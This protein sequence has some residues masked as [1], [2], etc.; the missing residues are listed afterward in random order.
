MPSTSID[1]QSAPTIPAFAILALSLAAFGSGISLRVT[2]ALLPKLS[3]DF[4][5]SLGE[6]SLVITVF[7]IAYG[8]AQLMFGPLGD[9]FGKYFVIA[10]G[11]GACAVTSLFCALAGSFPMLLV[12]R[13]VAGATA[14]AIIPLS[15]AWIGDVIP[16]QHRQPVLAKFLIGQILG[17]SAGV[18][19][20]GVAAE[21]FS[22]RMPFFGIA[23]LFVPIC[24]LLFALN[25]RLPATV[26]PVV[27]S[28]AHVISRMANEFALVLAKPW[29]RVVLITVF[30]E[31][32]FLYG[33]FAFFVAHLHQAFGL[34]LSTAGSLVMLYGFGGLA[35]AL[36][37]SM[38]VKRLGEIGLS[39]WGGICVTLSYITM[40]YAPVW[41]CAVPACFMAGLGF[42]MLHNTLQI[43]ATQMAVER[44]GVAVSAFAS[45]FFLG[46]ATGVGIAGM[47]VEKI[48]IPLVITLGGLGVLCVSQNFSRLRAARIDSVVP[49]PLGT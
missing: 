2:D 25:R 24:F 31:G 18:L 39:R 13:L 41:W 22:W 42:Y 40:A 10:C 3:S 23:A 34:P 32:L 33:A 37:A 29:A 4:A 19:L 27:T 7:S 8:I 30:L 35:F 47:L 12:A 5:I 1:L 26:A 43:N 15:M 17:L 11:C 6:A 9:R 20:G 49:T 48:G 46:Q 28:Q 21:H 38:L 16:Y 44:R 14:A 36:C 45:C